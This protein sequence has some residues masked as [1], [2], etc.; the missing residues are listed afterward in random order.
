MHTPPL[1]PPVLTE[2]GFEL[3]GSA[4]LGAAQCCDG[5]PYPL[6]TNFRRSPK[7]GKVWDILPKAVTLPPGRPVRALPRTR[8]RGNAIH[9]WEAWH[10]PGCRDKAHGRGLM[11]AR[12]GT[13]VGTRV[14]PGLVA[15]RTNSSSIL[16]SAF[17]Y[18][19]TAADVVRLRHLRK[20]LQR[21][22]SFVYAGIYSICAIISKDL[23]RMLCSQYCINE[24]TIN[25][26]VSGCV[27]HV[28][29]FWISSKWKAK[30]IKNFSKSILAK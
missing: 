7:R 16:M 15:P 21:S 25:T 6:K 5:S 23:L 17:V 1:S 20:R 18:A 13:D 11:S 8:V 19:V 9:Y 14:T 3:R 28:N 4:G 22:L 12:H 29:R 24:R 2:L 10:C 26:N 30:K 27:F